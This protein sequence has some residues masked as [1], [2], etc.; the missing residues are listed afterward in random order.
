MEDIAFI[1][2]PKCAGTSIRQALDIE[3]IGHYPVR[4]IDRSKLDDIFVFS[5]VRNPFD[6]M[7]SFY[8]FLRKGDIRKIASDNLSFQEWFKRTLVDKIHYYYYRPAFFDPCFDWLSIDGKLA[9]DFIGK[10]E[11]IERDWEKLCEKLGRSVILDKH[12]TTDSKIDTE[13]TNKMKQFMFDKY[14]KDFETWYPNLI[15]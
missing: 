11:N 5:F 2:I 4:D 15:E 8:R 3:K 7:A 12:N 13:Y 9:V 6:R 10:V 1:H 14:S